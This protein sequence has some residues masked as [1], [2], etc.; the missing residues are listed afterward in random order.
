MIKDAPSFSRLESPGLPERNQSG[1]MPAHPYWSGHGIPTRLEDVIQVSSVIMSEEIACKLVQWL[2]QKV[3]PVVPLAGSIGAGR[4]C[5]KDYWFPQLSLNSLRCMN[6]H[7]LM[8][9]VELQRHI[10]KY[11]SHM[12]TWQQKLQI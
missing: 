11:V 1:E 7:M 9:E 3:S 8:P 6:A 10:L 4:Q 5:V 2:G 12:P